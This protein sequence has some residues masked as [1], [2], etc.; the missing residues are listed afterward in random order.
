MESKATS[1][2]SRFTLRML[3]AM[4]EV[5]GKY[6]QNFPNNE[7]SIVADIKGEDSAFAEKIKSCKDLLGNGGTRDHSSTLIKID[8]LKVKINQISVDELKK[9]IN[10]RNESSIENLQRTLEEIDDKGYNDILRSL[11]LNEFW[12]SKHQ[13]RIIRGKVKLEACVLRHGFRMICRRTR[14]EGLANLAEAVH[15]LQ[16]ERAI[17]E[18]KTYSKTHNL[19]ERVKGLV[20]HLDRL[21]PANLRKKKAESFSELKRRTKFI[22]L[23]TN[24]Q[25]LENFNLVAQ[26]RHLALVFK[27]NRNM[28]RAGEVLTKM[29][30]RRGFQLVKLRYLKTKAAQQF[31]DSIVN[32]QRGVFVSVMIALRAHLNRAKEHITR[33]ETPKPPVAGS[34]FNNTNLCVISNN[35]PDSRYINPLSKRN[36]DENEV[37]KSK[38]LNNKESNGESPSFKNS[39]HLA[40]RVEEHPDKA[41][42]EAISKFKM[43][44]TIFSETS[45][46]ERNSAEVY[47][48]PQP[49]RYVES[50]IIHTSS[51]IKPTEEAKDPNIHSLQEMNRNESLSRIEMN[52]CLKESVPDSEFLK[53][54]EMVFN[55]KK[56]NY[57]FSLDNI[58]L[59]KGGRQKTEND[60]EGC[61]SRSG[62]DK[63]PRLKD[64]DLLMQ[65]AKRMNN[66][67]ELKDHTLDFLRS[68]DIDNTQRTSLKEPISDISIQKKANAAIVED[69]CEQPCPG[70]P[71]EDNGTSEPRRNA[72]QVEVPVTEAV[73]FVTPG[74]MG[75]SSIEV[76]RDR[77]ELTAIKEESTVID[78]SHI[79]SSKNNSNLI[80][81]RELI[82]STKRQREG[83]SSELQL[84][85]SRNNS[86]DNQRKLKISPKNK[87]SQQEHQIG[88]NGINDLEQ[89]NSDIKDKNLVEKESYATSE[90]SDSEDP[91]DHDDNPRKDSEAHKHEA[92]AENKPAVVNPAGNRLSLQNRFNV[93]IDPLRS[94]RNK[95]TASKPAH[96]FNLRKWNDNFKATASQFKRSINAK[97]ANKNAKPASQHKRVTNTNITRVPVAP[98]INTEIKESRVPNKFPGNSVRAQ[99]ITQNSFITPSVANFTQAK[100]RPASCLKEANKGGAHKFG[101][102]LVCEK[103]S[104]KKVRIPKSKDKCQPPNISAYKPPSKIGGHRPFSFKQST[105][106]PTA[107][108]YIESNKKVAFENNIVKY[109]P[110]PS[111]GYSHACEKAKSFNL[112]RS[113]SQPKAVK[114]YT[115]KG[116]KDTTLTRVRSFQHKQL[117]NSFYSS[118]GVLNNENGD[119]A[120][121][122]LP[123]DRNVTQKFVKSTINANSYRKSD[124]TNR[125]ASIKQE[126]SKSHQRRAMNRFFEVS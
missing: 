5:K 66:S 86:S 123:K 19:Y 107:K 58:D 46:G 53:Y 105:S 116:K 51:E 104:Y 52:S 3:E 37:K 31:S 117:Q 63:S 13:D 72:A 126:R 113:G 73:S 33:V 18:L 94:L 68:I 69:K 26:I 60:L 20:G 62:Y 29:A 106:K 9:S 34:L 97:S 54:C 125:V 40:A 41:T 76:I 85:K 42:N 7:V 24:R 110:K 95:I 2:K 75:R 87:S 30:K 1:I 83:L 55:A 65:F 22:D 35:N 80:E 124:A 101:I 96:E 81:S 99:N 6:S 121:Q 91:S 48:S 92:V 103:P 57:N 15:R 71:I 100:A 108:N 70:N 118:S 10:K 32:A 98:R 36:N 21:V 122:R 79:N 93:K 112:G 67:C 43:S 38:S 56:I 44:E 27:I 28:T 120:N 82:N 59:F 11:E 74:A 12:G 115:F 17:A 84:D 4:E 109:F 47:K 14:N 16:K 61:E 25:R 50:R 45:Y 88:S 114:N 78:K 89:L 39:L 77:R 90:S 111:E 23:I 119:R 8:A 49:L 64:V 102:R